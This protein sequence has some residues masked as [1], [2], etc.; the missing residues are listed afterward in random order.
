MLAAPVACSDG[1]PTGPGIARLIEEG[2]RIFRYDTFGDEQFWT[3]ALPQGLKDALLKLD[4]VVAHYERIFS[5][6]LS[7][8]QR[9]DLVQYLKS[10]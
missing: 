1:G 4:A 2:K 5:L 9:P 3:D 8:Q 10:L 7:A 6:S